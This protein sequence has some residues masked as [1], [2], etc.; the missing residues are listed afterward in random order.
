MSD[1]FIN[2]HKNF[3]NIAPE[4]MAQYSGLELLQRMIAGELPAPTMA[5][6]LN[7]I[8][9]EV[10]DGLA[11]FKGMATEDHYNPIGSVHGG[12]AGAIM[13]S[14]LGCAVHTKMPKGMGY[15]T[16]EFKVHLV[17]PI[18][19]HTG[20]VLCEG[21]VVHIGRT[22]ATSEATLKTLDGKLLA[23]GTETCALFPMK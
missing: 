11:V 2:T 3:G 6:T 17:R 7:F 8:L 22:I 21:K 4:I 16:I 12:W 13:D 14:A 15:S 18:F 1:G 5:R 19:K 9:S 10:D 23:H 20:E